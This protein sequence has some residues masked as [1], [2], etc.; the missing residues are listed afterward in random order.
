MSEAF[1]Y[2][3]DLGSQERPSGTLLDSLREDLARPSERQVWRSKVPARPG[4]VVVF[5]T[6]LD[7]DFWDRSSRESGR[8]TDSYDGLKLSGM[9]LAK[10]C[11]AIESDGKYVTDESGGVVT[12][13]SPLLLELT[14]ALTTREMLRAFYVSDFD[15]MGVADELLVRAG[16]IKRDGFDADENVDPTDTSIA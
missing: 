14:N 6:R 3:V 1:S 15:V 7:W 11:I 8:G 13:R 16:V 9:V 5:D 4:Y 10:Q 12:F 2:E